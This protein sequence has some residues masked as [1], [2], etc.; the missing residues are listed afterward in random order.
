MTSYIPSEHTERNDRSIKAE[1]R[2]EPSEAWP[3]LLDIGVYGHHSGNELILCTLTPDQ[4]LDLKTALDTYLSS[5]R[6]YPL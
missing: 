6:N 4:V 3:G 1:F 2:V 5:V